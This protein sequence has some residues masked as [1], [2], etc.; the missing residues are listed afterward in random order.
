M[1]DL[2]ITD[3]ARP[4]LAALT[5][6]PAA[7]TDVG[8]DSKVGESPVMS[9]AIRAP[10]PQAVAQLKAVGMLVMPLA[11]DQHLL[12]VSAINAPDFDDQ[13][14][15]N[16]A[17]LSQQ[18]VW[19]RLS[20]TKITDKSMAIVANFK[21]LIKINLEGTAITDEGLVL[22]AKLPYLESINV[23]GTKVTDAGLKQ[24]LSLK[25]LKTVYGWRSEITVAGAGSFQKQN[26][27]AQINVGI[28][29]KAKK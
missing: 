28:E 14:A 17:I 22:L 10:D 24:L 8:L 11:R 20:N 5:G 26:P 2:K 29:T 12:E 15:T 3:A 25:R 4:A 1:A 7:K 23:V 27:D 19:L 9:M 6:A 18:V 16:M 21:N 13:Q